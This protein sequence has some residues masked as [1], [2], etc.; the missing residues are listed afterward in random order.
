MNWNAFPKNSYQTSVKVGL[1][2]GVY[3]VGVALPKQLRFASGTYIFRI[4]F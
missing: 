2:A 3:S 4:P 1:A